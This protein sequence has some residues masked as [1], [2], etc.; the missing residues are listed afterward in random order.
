M[1][2]EAFARQIVDMM[3]VLYRVCY[4]QLPQAADREDAVQE[5]LRKA[6]EKRSKLRED[7]Y[8]QTWLI[9]ILIN[10]C[11]TIQ[12]KRKR[13]TLVET[14]PVDTRK[15]PSEDVRLRE[16]LLVLEESLRMPILLHYIEGYRIDEVA[17]MLKLPQG[18]IKTR[19]VRGRKQLKQI[20]LE[21]VFEG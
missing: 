15:F 8:L 6:W 7:K 17:Q 19:M 5:C 13:I 20:L 16:A 11:H 10:E 14:L 4:V 18:T 3:Q 1:T 2:S 9:R 21:E 12:R